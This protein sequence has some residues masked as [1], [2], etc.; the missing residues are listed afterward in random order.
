MALKKEV[1]V[2]LP[3]LGNMLYVIKIK[4]TKTLKI[5]TEKYRI[6]LHLKN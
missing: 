4:V 2:A 5:K 3:Y 1:G 6:N